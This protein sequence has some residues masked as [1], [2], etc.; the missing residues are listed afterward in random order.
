MDNSN[1]PQ[2]FTKACNFVWQDVGEGISR[3]IICYDEKLMLVKVSF[4]KDAIGA[5][6]QHHHTQITCIEQGVFEV[7]IQG[8]EKVL[9][10]GDSFYV[11]PGAMHGVRCLEPGVLTDM[12]SPMREDF[13]TT[14]L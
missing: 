13:L 4:A 2:L 3:C 12:F 11:P 1:T 10:A 14:V 8:E 6:H 7:T 9:S 5:M